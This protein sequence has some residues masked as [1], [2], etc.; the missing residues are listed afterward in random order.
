[1]NKEVYDQKKFMR[2]QNW[3]QKHSDF[4]G[5]KGLAHKKKMGIP[6]KKVGIPHKKFFL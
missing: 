1:M 2:N 3:Y 6:H 5:Y 4:D